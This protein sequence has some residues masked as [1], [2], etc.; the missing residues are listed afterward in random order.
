MSLQLKAEIGIPQKG[1]IFPGFNSISS[2]TMYL[3]NKT[4]LTGSNINEV[5]VGIIYFQEFYLRSF[6]RE[7]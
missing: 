2:N 6:L 1:P 3:Y 7:K 5:A 4:L